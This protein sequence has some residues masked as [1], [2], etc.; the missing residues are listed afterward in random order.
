MKTNRILKYSVFG[1]CAILI[2]NISSCTTQPK[3]EL[4]APS[5]KRN[6]MLDWYANSL[7]VPQYAKLKNAIDSLDESV[8]KFDSTLNLT[9]LNQTQRLW[10]NVVL[11]WHPCIV[12]EFGPSEKN[13]VKLGE[14]ISVWPVDTAGIEKEVK[15]V[16][17]THVPK[18]K[19]I[20]ATEYLIFN[21][22][23]IDSDIVNRLSKSSDRRKKL[24]QIVKEIK[25]KINMVNTEWQT[26]KLDFVK[27]DGTQSGSSFSLL[28]NE[29]VHSYENVKNFKVAI[30]LGQKP[31][32]TQ[33]YPE[34][35]EAYYSGYSS[36]FL[37]SHLNSVYRFWE[38][39]SMNGT[40]GIGLKDYINGISNG[41][42]LSDSTVNQWKKIET[43][44]QNIPQTPLNQTIKNNKSSLE[45]LFEELQRHTRFFKSELSSLIAVNITY[46]S[47]DGD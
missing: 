29:F 35:V 14:I 33:V 9:Q 47:G 31:G 37:S 7:I 19:G 38:G 25:D 21:L 45:K 39:K 27:N 6:E 28:Y 12:Y 41:K 3:N 43:S 8:S 46:A 15:N 36:Q 23:N 18:F 34:K 16:T 17:L 4:A 26:Y 32:L 11:A 5:V 22:S 44:L 24:K 40:K 1:V 13:G 2:L 10:R 20:Y 30:P 42:S